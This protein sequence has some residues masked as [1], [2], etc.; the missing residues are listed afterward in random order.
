MLQKIIWNHDECLLNLQHL[1]LSIR[2]KFKPMKRLCFSSFFLVYRDISA[3]SAWLLNLPPS[4]RLFLKF[5]NCGLTD[6]SFDL[7]FDALVQTVSLIHALDLSDN[8]LTSRSIA[9]ILALMETCKKCQQ[10]E[11]CGLHLQDR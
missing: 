2:Q 1:S 9:K 8:K 6:R 7:L 3:L 11:L 5:R 10:W 4:T